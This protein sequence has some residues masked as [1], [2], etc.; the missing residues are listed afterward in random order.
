[1]RV[2]DVGT[3][4]LN[5]YVDQRKEQGAANATVNREMATLRRMFRLGYF[6]DP[7]QVMRLPKFP[8]LDEDDNVRLGFLEPED[9]DRLAA[10]AT[11]LWMRAMLEVYHVYGWRKKEVMGMKIKQ[12]DFDQR[13]IRLDIGT[14]K[15]K[16]GREAPMN[17][18]VF[19]LLSEC[20]HGKKPDDALFTRSNGKPVRDFRT[21]WRN[22]CI[23]AGIGRMI[24]RLCHKTVVGKKCESCGCSDLKYE[25]RIVHDMRRTAAR[26]LRRIGI[27]EGVIMKIGGWKT[28]SV[29]ERYNIVD[30]RDKREAIEKLEKAEL[31]R[32]EHKDGH[33][34]PTED[35]QHASNETQQ[36]N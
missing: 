21:S 24:C 2:V 32:L 15:N 25:G 19:A 13:L 30:Q 1:M 36:V 31:E 27:A 18:I 7:P 6:S 35:E 9:Y 10:A 16:Q 4:A 5:K 22:L 12:V 33:D 17:D 26:N 8:R 34:D 11:E 20:A 29:F 14:T 28:R 3:T 23:G